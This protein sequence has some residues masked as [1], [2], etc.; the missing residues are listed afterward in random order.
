MRKV[1]TIAS[2]LFVITAQRPVGSSASFLGSAAGVCAAGPES[3]PHQADRLCSG[4]CPASAYL[5][6]FDDLMSARYLRGSGEFGAVAVGVAAASSAVDGDG[7]LGDRAGRRPGGPARRTGSEVGKRAGEVGA[8]AVGLAVAGSPADGD[9]FLGNWQ[10][11]G[12]AAQLGEPEANLV[13]DRRGRG[14]GGRGW[15]WPARGG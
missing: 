11:V 1:V 7:F 9:G 3:P 5:F 12:R 8:V 13:S 15:R 2:S 14:G 6:I 10:G 4:H